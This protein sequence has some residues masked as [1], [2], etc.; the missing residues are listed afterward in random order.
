NVG[1]VR[2]VKI[3]VRNTGVADASTV[4]VYYNLPKE[5][6]LVSAEPPQQQVADEPGALSW[7]LN[8]VAAGSEQ[9]IAV[10]VKPAQTGTID[11][12]SS[13]TLRVGARAHTTIQE[14]LLK[15]EQTVSP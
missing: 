8:T 5:L 11:H 14:P 13:V 9:I 12:T 2:T 7:N 3:I 4:R 15:V 6:T 1:K 10:K